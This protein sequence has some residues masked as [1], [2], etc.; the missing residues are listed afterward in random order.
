[1]MGSSLLDTY[2]SQTV[3]AKRSDV[4][5]YLAALDH[6][7]QAAPSIA[8]NIIKELQTQRATL[9]L[10]ASE[11][12]SSLSV[13]LA[14]GNLLTDKYCEGFPYHRFYAGCENVDAIE[15]EAVELAKQL[16]GSAHA[17]VQPHL[18]GCPFM[19]AFWAILTQ[20]VQNPALEKL[21]KKTLDELSAAEFETVRQLL[22][23]QLF[24]GNGSELWW[25]F[26]PRF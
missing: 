24:H 15:S 9:K 3:V 26:D 12:Y 7:R 16:F 6:L 13:Q 17:Y 10:I 23:N 18:E 14:M 25:P 5:A 19:V 4:I 11:N 2:L 21:G 1:M 8:E 22:C 20:R